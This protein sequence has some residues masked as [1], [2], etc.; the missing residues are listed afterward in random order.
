MTTF[1]FH[2]LKDVLTRTPVKFSET[3]KRSEIFGINENKKKT[4][5]QYLTKEAYLGVTS[6][7][8]YGTKIDRKIA[9]QV[10]ALMKERAMSKGVTHYTH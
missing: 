4:M 9:D 1:R 6:A 2:V 3:E 10:A 5:R 8:K 7:I